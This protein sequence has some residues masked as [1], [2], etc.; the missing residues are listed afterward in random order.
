MK[1]LITSLMVMLTTGILSAQDIV[2]IRYWVN[3]D[4]G[5]GEGISL[6]DNF[7]AEPMVSL[8]SPLLSTLTEDLELGNHLLGF[9]SKD[10]NG[11]W[12]H[13]QFHM[14]TLLEQPSEP[15]IESMEYWVDNDGA[16]GTEA[17]IT[18]F[19]N[20]VESLVHNYLHQTD[21]EAWVGNHILG[22]RS[23]DSDGKWSHTN[24]LLFTLA[25]EPSNPH[26]VL[27]EYFWSD[28]DYFGEFTDAQ[29]ATAQESTVQ[30]SF[31]IN[32]PESLSADENATLFVRSLD[33]DGKW[34]H[35]NYDMGGGTVIY[36]PPVGETVIDTTVCDTFTSPGGTEVNTNTSVS[37]DEFTGNGF[38]TFTYNVSIFDVNTL[39]NTQGTIDGDTLAI[40]N[41]ENAVYQWLDCE[42]ELAAIPGATGQVFTPETQGSYAVEVTQNGCSDISDCVDLQI[43]SSV[44]DLTGAV[45]NELIAYPNP[46]QS[47]LN[48]KVNSIRLPAFATMYDNTGKKVLEQALNHTVTT[49]N[50]AHLQRGIYHLRVGEIAVSVIL[51]R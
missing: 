20:G 36:A 10:S 35:T 25:Q 1:V 40:A 2:D 46:A 18:D 30:N 29:I 31:A 45:Q 33:S 42:D 38:E 26:I 3:A 11:K 23:K 16:F 24:F 15:T 49:L 4:P 34:S 13:T 41:A 21:Q 51:S 32:V 17:E 19:E 44:N 28:D 50:V 6:A 7:T 12:S 5:V 9:R 8:S 37:E 48:L 43:V 39:I 22:I 14:L 47:V 27:I